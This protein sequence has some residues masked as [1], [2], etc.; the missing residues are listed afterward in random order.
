MPDKNLELLE[1]LCRPRRNTG[2]RR[3]LFSTGDGGSWI[4]TLLATH[5]ERKAL[6]RVAVLVLLPFHPLSCEELAVIAH[7]LACRVDGGRC[8]F[9][10]GVFQVGGDGPQ[11]RGG[12]L[13]QEGLVVL[14]QLC[15][16][17]GS[18]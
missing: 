15:T 2:I 1:I 4:L 3:S 17:G 13:L 14:Q 5:S 8:G 9:G 10:C 18:C 12:G 6:E 7:G 11:V 16:V